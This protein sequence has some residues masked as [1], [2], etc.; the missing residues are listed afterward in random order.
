MGFSLGKEAKHNR[1]IGSSIS[2]LCVLLAL[3]SVLVRCDQAQY[4][5]QGGFGGA[6]GFGGSS[7]GFGGSGFG[8]GNGDIAEAVP[9]IPGAD[10]PIFAEVPQSSFFCGGRVEGGYYADPEAD[11]QAFHICAADAEGGLTKYSFLCPNGTLFN[12]QYFICDWWFNVDCSLAENLYSRNDEIAAE[13][14]RFSGSAGGNAGYNG[15]GS[16]AGTRLGSGRPSFSSGSGSFSSG[17]STGS[18]GFTQSASG[19]YASPS[20]STRVS[21]TRISGS[22]GFTRSASG[23]YSSP[24]T[25]G[26]VSSSRLGGS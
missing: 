2:S 9:G 13:R 14:Q 12:Q 15:R 18:T 16:T 23:S 11:C 24:S 6:R 10:Y 8:G 17:R 21:N 19:S 5:S 4:G 26:R 22:T 20:S 7:G 25:N 3:G 1:M